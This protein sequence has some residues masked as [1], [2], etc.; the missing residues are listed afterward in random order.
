[1]GHWQP[2]P[3]SAENLRLFRQLDQL[4]L[5]RL[6]PWHLGRALSGNFAY[7]QRLT[8]RFAT[9]TLNPRPSN[10]KLA[11]SGMEGGELLRNWEGLSAWSEIR[12]SSINPENWQHEL[13]CSVARPLIV[14]P[15]LVGK[16][17][18]ESTVVTGERLFT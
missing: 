4:Y 15:V 3:E 13:G 8:N 11:G 12:T 9:N 18:L 2:L 16:L 7:C 1:M 6:R 14:H 17:G 5:K 10:A